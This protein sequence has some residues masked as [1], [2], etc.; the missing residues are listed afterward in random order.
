[1]T[2]TL[3]RAVALTGMLAMA[4][5]A[6]A[7]AGG[8]MTFERALRE[9]EK[10]DL[11][12]L[13][14]VGASWCSSCNAF[15]QATLD[16]KAV[17]AA[18]GESAI[19]VTVDAED[20]QG[21][22]AKLAKKF[23]AHNYPTFILTNASG[24]VLDRWYGYEKAEEFVASL[25]EAA[26]NPMTI[27]ERIAH[28]Q[29]E[30]NEKDAFKIADLRH[31]EGLFAEAVAYYQRAGQLNPKSEKNYEAHI[32]GA[33]AYGNYYQM[34]TADQ[35]KDQA[36]IVLASSNTTDMGY[37]KVAK[38]MMKVAHR[39]KTTVTI[40]RISRPPSS[41]PRTARTRMSWRCAST[42]FRTTRS[43]SRRTRR[44]PSRTRRTRCRRT[45]WTTPT[46]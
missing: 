45:G 16:D 11:P 8:D 46:S 35:V 4:F 23:R 21:G 19:L 10:A 20:K 40:C 37:M 15:D 3:R 7:V 6:T 17:K 43:T 28:F 31:H 18:I 30:P 36:D 33:M 41:A 13:L 25:A 12:V 29:S 42:S 22:G 27:D 39:A 44:A 14:K 1:M 2:K 34:Y 24:E 26:D 9:A 38:S 32:F 5:A